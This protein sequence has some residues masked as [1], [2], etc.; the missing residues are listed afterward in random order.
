MAPEKSDNMVLGASVMWYSVET[1]ETSSFPDCEWAV[2][3]NEQTCQHATMG[4]WN[5]EVGMNQNQIGQFE[6]IRDYGFRVIYGNWAFQKNRSARR[7][8]PAR[9]RRSYTSG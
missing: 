9:R 6:Q 5:W 3:F 1:E 7:A 8:N 2:Q 4:E